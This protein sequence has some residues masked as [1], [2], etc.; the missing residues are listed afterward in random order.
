MMEPLPASVLPEGVRSRLLPGINGLTVHL[1]E[2]GFEQPGRPLILLLHGFPEIA[3]SWRS[4]MPRLSAAGFHVVAPDARGYGRTTGAAT[5]YDVDLWDFGLLNLVR[6]ALQVVSALGHNR[7]ALVAGHDYGASVAAAC[8]LVRPD[9]FASVSLMSAPFAGPPSRP[10][11]PVDLEAEL[12][13]LDPPRKHY[14]WYYA[15]RPAAADLDQPEQGLHAFLRAYF[16]QKSADWPGNAPH[17][18]AGWSAE[19][20][21]QLPDYYVMP[22]HRTMPQAVAPAMPS[23]DEIAAC[24]WLT[25]RDLAVYTAEYARTGFQGGLNFY[26]LRSA[27]RHAQELATFAGRSIDIPSCFFAGDKDWGTYQKPG[28]F[29]AMQTRACTDMRTCMLLPGAGHWIQQEQPE[30]LAQHLLA[31]VGGL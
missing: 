13:R 1:L 25:E 17:P 3:F 18:L 14:H 8:A 15:T 2:S 12:A 20:I 9:V 24:R 21:A 7:V 28:D 4:I 22:L 29:E 10:G 23:P 19:E 31:F 30:L 5:G 26:R 16:H 6:D 11:P 27:G